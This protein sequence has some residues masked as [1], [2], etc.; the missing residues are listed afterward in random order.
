MFNIP[1]HAPAGNELFNEDFFKPG[2]PI[3]KSG[4]LIN[5]NFKPKYAG[6]NNLFAAGSI[7][8]YSETMKYGCGHGMAI[9]TGIAA[10]KNA[11]EYI[12]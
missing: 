7:L 8:A 1:V 10:A 9:S 6:Y 3:E 4:I 12:K 2:H 11:E 5:D